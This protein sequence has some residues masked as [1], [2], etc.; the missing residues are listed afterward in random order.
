[1]FNIKKKIKIYFLESTL[2]D[3]LKEKSGASD[4]FNDMTMLDNLHG[5]KTTNEDSNMI[6][7][8]MNK[9]EIKIAVISDLIT[10]ERQH[11]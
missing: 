8:I 10:E 11:N 3:L 4:R 5:H 6:D 2:K 7:N 1:M 9:I